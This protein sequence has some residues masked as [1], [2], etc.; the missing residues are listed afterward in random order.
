MTMSNDEIIR[1]YLQSKDQRKQIGILADLNGCDKEKIRTILIH[2]GV[3]LPTPG[4]PKKE[5]KE[6]QEKIE[7]KREAAVIKKSSEVL[8]MSKE[9]HKEAHKIV[10][11]PEK[12]KE[13]LP[14]SVLTALE[15]RI[16]EIDVEIFELNF[17]KEEIK[18][19]LEGSN[20]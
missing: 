7:K 1:A 9:A 6:A 20:E 8:P 13:P 15:K 4:R 17:E 2:H 11:V 3:K 10:R 5:I 12:I 16:E 19:F 14:M 18:R